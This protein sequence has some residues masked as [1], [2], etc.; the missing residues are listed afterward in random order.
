ML[1]SAYILGNSM[2]SSTVPLIRSMAASVGMK[3]IIVL[4][5]FWVPRICNHKTTHCF[6]SVVPPQCI[7]INGKF[8]Y[9]HSAACTH[10][11]NCP[12]FTNKESLTTI[13]FH[14]SCYSSHKHQIIQKKLLRTFQFL[15]NS[16]NS[17]CS[18]QVSFF[19]DQRG[20]TR[21]WVYIRIKWQPAQ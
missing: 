18:S 11:C 10:I 16:G 20:I 3:Q 13:L 4:S 7:V 9:G 2:I 1:L 5:E 15:T 19:Y 14:W 8:R 12:H 21:M 17:D 6:F